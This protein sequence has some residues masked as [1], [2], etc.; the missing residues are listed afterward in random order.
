MTIK[1]NEKIVLITGG[2][3]GIGFITA[4][5]YAK[6][7]ASV[8]ITARSKDKGKNAE[9]FIQKNYG[10]CIFFPADVSNQ[11]EVE[12]LFQFIHQKYKKLDIA[13]NNAGIDGQSFTVTHEYPEEMCRQV[14][15]T[16]VLG[17]WYCLKQEIILM[18]EKSE[19]HI[20][21]VAS[22]ASF[23]ASLTGGSPYTASKHAVIGIT[24]SAAKEYAKSGIRINAVC[25]GLVATDDVKEL[26]KNGTI[27]N[28]EEIHPIGRLI[29][30]IEVAQAIINMTN[31]MPF[32]TG[33][34]L[35]IE[36][37]VLT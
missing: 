11:H 36:G 29:E 14:L 31:H 37:G 12:T 18:L 9:A 28:T 27:T 26:I 21:N 15:N 13:I 25:P 16:N 30:P 19:G 17:L 4:C 5:E 34:A 23:K 20:V 3:Q 7:G 2:T 33:I 32:L 35:P 8:V 22:A 1:S 24:R 10:T 6:L